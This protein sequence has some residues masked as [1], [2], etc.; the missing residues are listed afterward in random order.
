[1]RFVNNGGRWAQIPDSWKGPLYPVIDGDPSTGIF[2]PIINRL[3]D[4]STDKFDALIAILNDNSADIITGGIL[5]CA[6]GVMLSPMIDSSAGKWYGRMFAVL[7]IGV[8][9]R[10]ML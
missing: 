1:M 2:T 9:W 3:S 5:V 10:V 4:W 6:F 8:V 7:W